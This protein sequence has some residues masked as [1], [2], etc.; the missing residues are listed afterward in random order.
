MDS[1][2]RF[3]RSLV[4]LT[5][6]S[7]VALVAVGL[8]QGFIGGA[9]WPFTWVVLLPAVALGAVAVDRRRAVVV[10]AAGVFVL[11]WQVFGLY[12]FGGTPWLWRVVEGLTAM[13]GRVE[14]VVPAV[15]WVGMVGLFGVWAK[16]FDP[17]ARWGLSVAR[18]AIAVAASVAVY[19]GLAW[20]QWVLWTFGLSRYPR[21]WFVV[22]FAPAVVLPLL[23][24]RR[25]GEVV[26]WVGAVLAPAVM[27]GVVMLDSYRPTPMD[28]GVYAVVLAIGPMWVYR[29]WRRSR[30]EGASYGFEV[31]VA[32]PV[33]PIDE[34]TL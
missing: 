14:A 7:G 10:A 22:E 28:F 27:V 17:G 16:L 29:D 31:M 18:A 20:L 32:R 24:W 4:L 21:L 12:W 15:F 30:T 34:G 13:G 23:L 9:H 2:Q 11:T 8:A 19:Y 3:T 33:L 5:L 26:A 1:P 25:W 6:A